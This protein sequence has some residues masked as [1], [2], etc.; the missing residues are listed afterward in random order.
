MKWNP[1]DF[2]NIQCTHNIFL[3]QSF[4]VCPQTAHALREKFAS[5]TL[6]HQFSVSSSAPATSVCQSLCRH[7]L[8]FRTNSCPPPPTLLWVSQTMAGLNGICM[9]SNLQN[10]SLIVTETSGQYSGPPTLSVFSY[11]LLSVKKSHL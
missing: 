11:F 2:Q 1:S 7:T 8:L 6:V 9:L 10:A 3:L 4:H 5:P